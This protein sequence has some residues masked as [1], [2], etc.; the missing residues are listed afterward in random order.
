MIF[1]LMISNVLVD[2][3][4]GILLIIYTFTH[5]PEKSR[6]PVEFNLTIGPPK[7]MEEHFR[8]KREEDLKKY[9]SCFED[10]SSENETEEINEKNKFS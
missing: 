3:I 1:L 10:N 6:K 9:A 7:S 8:K 4:A 5:D 2:V